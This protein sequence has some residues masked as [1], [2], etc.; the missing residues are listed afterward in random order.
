MAKEGLLEKI[1]KKAIFAI[2]G[3]D[4]D[5]DWS[6]VASKFV[7]EKAQ[8][9][10]AWVADMQQ[11]I[12][13]TMLKDGDI[14]PWREGDL[15]RG[16]VPDKQI[17]ERMDQ[18]LLATGQKQM[19]HT[20]KESNYRPSRGAEKDEKFFTYRDSDRI[21]KIVASFYDKFPEIDNGIM[22]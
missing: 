19:Y 10:D 13:P 20:M 1:G 17:K 16:R 3:Y 22:Y 9:N 4:Y 21:S 5:Q 8:F 15:A 14:K 12:Y 18:M 6:N 2:Q 7:T 11:R